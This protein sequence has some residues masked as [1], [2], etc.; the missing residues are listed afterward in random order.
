[1]DK[2]LKGGLRELSEPCYYAAAVVLNYK[3]GGGSGRGLAACR[4]SSGATAAR[5]LLWCGMH[6]HPTHVQ[7]AIRVHAHANRSC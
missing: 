6:V 5:R 2:E 4:E 7:S 1:M 3:E